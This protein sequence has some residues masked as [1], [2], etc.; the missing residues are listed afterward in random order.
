MGFHI[1]I[2]SFQVA[3]GAKEIME[4][5]FQVAHGAKERMA[6]SQFAPIKVE[7]ELQQQHRDQMECNVLIRKK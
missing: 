3:R 7:A 5:I 6:L 2:Q 1:F 4:S